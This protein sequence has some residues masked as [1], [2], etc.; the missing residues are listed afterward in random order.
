MKKE[1]EWIRGWNKM[2]EDD[3]FI[4]VIFNLTPALLFIISLGLFVYMLWVCNGKLFC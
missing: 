4:Y 2:N 3:R 1:M